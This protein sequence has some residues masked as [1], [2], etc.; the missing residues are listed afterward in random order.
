MNKPFEELDYQKTDRG[1]LILRRRKFPMLDDKIVYEVILGQEFLMSSLFHAAEDAL[2]HLGIKELLPTEQ[3]LDIIVGGLGLGYTAAAA[4]E[5][6]EVGKLTV[7]DIFPE[8]IG[9]HEQGLVPL[10]EQLTADPRC[11]FLQADFFAC[12]EGSGFHPDAPDSKVDAV[13]LDIDHTHDF[14]LHPDHAGF[15]SEKGLAQL[16]SHLRPR[17]VFAMWADGKPK[18]EFIQLLAKVFPEARGELITFDNPLQGGQSYGT[19]YLARRA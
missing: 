2:S 13:L 15:Y 4:L 14:W 11:Q 5:H 12:A 8:L 16:S 3:P 10:G 7:V 19:V 17:G 18:D 1:D 6:P 9:W